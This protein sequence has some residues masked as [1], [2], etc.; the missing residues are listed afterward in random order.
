MRGC[1]NVKNLTAYLQECVDL[2]TILLNDTCATGQHAVVGSNTMTLSLQIA[3]AC[4]ALSIL[5]LMVFGLTYMLRTRFMPYH[6]QALRQEWHALSSPLQ[7]LILALMRAT[8]GGCLTAAFFATL[9]LWTPFRQ[10]EAWAIWTLPIGGLIMSASALYAMR[11]VTRNTS[12]KPP[13]FPV[14]LA[15]GSS[16]AGAA[17][18]YLG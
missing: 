7:G 6:G 1:A 2:F 9:I 10:G 8:A 12:A 11:L 17:F 4:H 18:S 14:M 15:G 13:F 16:L 3:F 5:T